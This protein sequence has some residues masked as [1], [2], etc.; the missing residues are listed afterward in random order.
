MEEH[1]RKLLT[2]IAGLNAFRDYEGSLDDNLGRL[3]ALAAEILDAGRC[4]VMLVSEDSSLRVCANHGELPDAAYREAMTRGEGISGHVASTGKSLLIEDI[5]NS[6]FAR[7]AR[8]PES[9][10]GSMVSSPVMIDSNVIGVINISG[11]SAPFDESD[12]KA[13]EIVAMFAGKIIQIIQLRSVL[14]SRFAQMSLISSN[15]RVDKLFEEAE[16]PERMARILAKSFYRE[17]TKA[18]FG[19]AQ[20]VNAATQIISELSSTLGRHRDRMERS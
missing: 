12:L 17:M 1:A 19:S 11:R 5:S 10:E 9:G 2:S 16:N 14:N 6:A 8:H 18:G 15:G 7:L 4:S 3:S 13:L 20:I